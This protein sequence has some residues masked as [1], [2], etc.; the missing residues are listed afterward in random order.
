M[1]VRLLGFC[2][3]LPPHR[4]QRWEVPLTGKE[5]HIFCHV[6]VSQSVLLVSLLGEGG[7]LFV[8]VWSN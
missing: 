4:G 1:C 8:G 7:A 6:L 3:F 2:D 5:R